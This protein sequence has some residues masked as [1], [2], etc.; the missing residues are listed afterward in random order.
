MSHVRRALPALILASTL[1]TACHSR[2]AGEPL[3]F[4][5]EDP[6]GDDHGDGE[7]VYPVRTDLGRGDLDVVS[8]QALGMEGGTRFEVT[9]AHPIARPTRAHTVD[10][11]GGTLADIARH[12]FY[13]FNVDIY[14]DQDHVVGS[15]RTDTLPGRGLALAPESAW[16]KALV[17]TPRPYEAREQLHKRWRQVALAAHRAEHGP[18]SGKEERRLEAV[19][20]QEVDARVF[21]ATR[22]QVSGRTVSFEVPDAFLGEHARADWGYA[23]AV[24]GASLDRKVELSLLGANDTQASGLMVMG[25]GPGVSEARF[26]GARTGDPDQSP[27]V[28]LLVPSGIAQEAVL[29]PA[30]SPWPAVVPTPAA[31]AAVPMPAPTEADGTP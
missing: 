9:F 19:A 18:V 30:K 4:R 14:V 16:D 27:V 22:I 15:G 21:F 23:V 2:R 12:G 20:D 13:T 3:L 28:D 6:V 7:L 8:V 29:G 25:I 5:L 24:T 31:S 11:G 10:I 26:G 17:L 1:S